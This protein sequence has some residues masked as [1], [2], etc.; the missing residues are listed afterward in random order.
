VTG[1]HDFEQLAS[2]EDVTCGLDTGGKA[3]CWDKTW[4]LP[5]AVSPALTLEGIFAGSTASHACAL[6]AAGNA[7][8]MGGNASGQLGDGTT[9]KSLVLRQVKTSHRFVTLTTGEDHTCGLT[10][11]GVALCLGLQRRRSARHGRQL[12]LEGPRP[13]GGHQD[14]RRHQRRRIPHLRRGRGEVD[15]LLGRGCQRRAGDRHEGRG[16]PHPHRHL[17]LDAPARRLG[18]RLPH[19]RGGGPSPSPSPARPWR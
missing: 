7:W 12:R 2:G 15:P 16:D 19:L 11:G 14:L 9:T 8:C 4:K 3:W 5:L 10:T 6:D 13:G 1:D 17:R 18:G